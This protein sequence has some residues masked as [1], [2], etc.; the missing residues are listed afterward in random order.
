MNIAVILAGG[1][2]TRMGIPIPKQFMNICGKPLIIRTI[3]I[4]QLSPRIDSICIICKKE[5]EEQLGIWINEYKISKVKWIFN[6]GVSRQQSVYNFIKEFS[7]YGVDEDIVLIH[8]AARPMVTEKIIDDNI[9]CAIK[10]DAVNTV[11]PSADTIIRSLDGEVLYEVPVRHQL[12][13]CQTPQSF[14]YKLIKDAHEYAIKENL[15]DSTD[16]CQLVLKYGAEVHLVPGSKLNFKITTEEDLQ[17]FQS[18]L[19]VKM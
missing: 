5:Y 13:L 1:S 3:E 11:I 17:I 10:Y 18:I 8:D 16:D 12:Y 19:N 6:G 4:F 2:G 15:Q 7:K 14:K 9:D